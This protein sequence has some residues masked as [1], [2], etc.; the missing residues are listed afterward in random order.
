M[1]K[2]ILNQHELRVVSRAIS[3]SGLSCEVI[4]DKIGVHFTMVYRWKRCSGSPTETNLAKLATVLGKPA[5]W[6]NLSSKGAA[7]HR[8]QTIEELASELPG[9]FATRIRYARMVAGLTTAELSTR[10]GTCPSTITR[11]EGGEDRRPRKTSIDNLAVAMGVDPIW[12]STGKGVM[13][14]QS[15]TDKLDE[16]K[17]LRLALDQL[18][19]VCEHLTSRLENGT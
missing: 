16:I 2:R 14:F 4:A 9:S 13:M 19:L 6:P 7:S 12:L 8:R 17:T 11:W 3:E 18:A 15:N 10:L 5:G 1:P